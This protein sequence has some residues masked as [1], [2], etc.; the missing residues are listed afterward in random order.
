MG[1][2]FLENGLLSVLELGQKLGQ[3][4][5]ALCFICDEN[6]TTMVLPGTWE[7]LGGITRKHFCV[8]SHCIR[9][10]I[11]DI[12]LENRLSFIDLPGSG[13]T[14]WER[15]GPLSASGYTFVGMIV[16]KV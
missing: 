9:L 15:Y 16:N 2:C 4:I 10:N 1:N 8:K 3:C 12:L 14:L 5:K 6:R 13:L 7:S 11:F